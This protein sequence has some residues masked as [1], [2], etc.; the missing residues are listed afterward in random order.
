M[1]RENR[2]ALNP[3]LSL[4]QEIFTKTDGMCRMGPGP[5]GIGVTNPQESGICLLLLFE[6]D[7]MK[8]LGELAGGGSRMEVT[9]AGYDPVRWRRLPDD[10][11]KEMEGEKENPIT[12]KIASAARELSGTPRQISYWQYEEAFALLADWE[13]QEA[14][15]AEKPALGGPVMG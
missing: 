11:V 7:P 15:T 12:R 3:L 6:P 9:V 5:G 1:D 10:A 8:D 14:K 13:I 2:I 4:G